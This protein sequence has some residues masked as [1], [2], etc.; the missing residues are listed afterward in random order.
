[1]YP[2][3]FDEPLDPSDSLHEKIWAQVPVSL[4]IANKSYFAPNGATWNRRDGPM[5]T[6]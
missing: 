6:M 4:P 1:M 2:S 3:D 5:K